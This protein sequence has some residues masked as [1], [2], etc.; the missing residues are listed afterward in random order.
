MGHSSHFICTSNKL[1]Y[2]WSYIFVHIYLCT[3]ICVFYVEVLQTFSIVKPSASLSRFIRIYFRFQIK[4]IIRTFMSLQLLLSLRPQ[5]PD[6][7][8]DH[9]VRGYR[10]EYFVFTVQTVY[11]LIHLQL[12]KICTNNLFYDVVLD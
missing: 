5:G 3:Y 4:I 6:G 8:N 11:I 1:L 10:W 9:P 12:Y 2:T 7:R